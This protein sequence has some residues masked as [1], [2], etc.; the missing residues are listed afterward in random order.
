MSTVGSL[1]HRQHSVV[2][3]VLRVFDLVDTH[4]VVLST[5]Y[6]GD[7]SELVSG[8]LPRLYTS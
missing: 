4:P 3:G 2:R 6:R 7:N 5:D 8:V 1:E